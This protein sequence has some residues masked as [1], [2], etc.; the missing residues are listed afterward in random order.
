MHQASRM[1]AQNWQALGGLCETVTSDDDFESLHA[2]A[3]ESLHKH[4]KKMNAHS[5]RE[6]RSTKNEIVASQKTYNS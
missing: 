2:E 6:K 5:S 3:Y 1:S 4:V